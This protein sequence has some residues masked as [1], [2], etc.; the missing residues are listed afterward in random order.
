M[1]YSNAPDRKTRT[2]F[3]VSIFAILSAKTSG[4]PTCIASLY[5]KIIANWS[6]TNSFMLYETFFQLPLLTYD[7]KLVHPID[8][9]EI[10]WI[11]KWKGKHLIYC[12]AKATKITD[13]I[14][15]VTFKVVT[16]EDISNE[17]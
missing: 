2:S 1:L 11:N 17:Q 12:N 8:F 5:S 15:I 14:E 7:S 4:F 13:T 3:M 16:V 10:Q 6:A 9:Y